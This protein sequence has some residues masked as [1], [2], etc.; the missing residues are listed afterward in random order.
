[1]E[2]KYST[3]PDTA[4]NE[5]DEEM[6]VLMLEEAHYVHTVNAFV[7]LIEK[8]GWSQVIEDLRAAMGNK[9]WQ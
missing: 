5:H 4:F 2:N 7:S 6:N 9:T 3:N 1:M 8:Y